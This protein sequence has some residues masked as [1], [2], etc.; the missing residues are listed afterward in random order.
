MTW[1][2]PQESSSVSTG[3]GSRPFSVNRV[4]LV[5]HAIDDAMLG[6]APQAV[7]QYRTRD[8]ELALEV[9]EA[10]GAEE[11]LADQEQCPTIA[12]DLERRSHRTV[13]VGVVARE[14]KRSLDASVR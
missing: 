11:R 7:A 8:A 1:R 10:A 13:L 5:A 3:Q 2:S 9:V 6:E 4:L 12:D 14:H